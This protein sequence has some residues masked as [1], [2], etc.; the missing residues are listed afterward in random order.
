MISYLLEK[1]HSDD[2]VVMVGDT[3]FD[4]LGAAELGIPTI[5]VSWGYGNAEDMK[6]AGAAA[7]ADTMEQLYR[8]LQ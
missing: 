5:A 4:V 3:V 7:V 6:N 8:L 1:I 2:K